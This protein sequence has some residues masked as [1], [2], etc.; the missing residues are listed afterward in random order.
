VNFRQFL[1]RNYMEVPFPSLAINEIP[2]MIRNEP[3][4][5]KIK[6]FKLQEN[7]TYLTLKIIIILA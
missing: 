3:H 4:G 1:D 5:Q 2:S 6:I 7:Q